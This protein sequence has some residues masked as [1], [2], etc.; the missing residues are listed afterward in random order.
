MSEE[1]TAGRIP[2]ATGTDGRAY[3]SCDDAVQLLRAIAE[4]CRTLADDPDCDLRTAAAAIDLNADA[5]TVRAIT[6][7]G[8]S[9]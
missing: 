3:L 9:T 5:L 4:S 6:R 7:T 2:L 8:R 1:P